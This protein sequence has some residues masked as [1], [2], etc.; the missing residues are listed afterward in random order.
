MNNNDK[1]IVNGMAIDM[2]P[3]EH[4]YYNVLHHLADAIIKHPEFPTENLVEMVAIMSEESGEAIRAANNYQHESGT[5][6][7]LKEE[8]YQT[9]A[10]CLRCLICLDDKTATE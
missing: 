5:I 4:H 2:K 8:L 9:A 10:M 3:I 6:E 7:A 1:I